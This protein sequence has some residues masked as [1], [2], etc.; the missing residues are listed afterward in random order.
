MYNLYIVHLKEQVRLKVQV[1]A[2]LKKKYLQF[3]VLVPFLKVI[4]HF[5]T[6]HILKSLQICI[7][8]SKYLFKGALQHYTLLVHLKFLQQN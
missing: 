8:A 5:W 1:P 7:R 2:H 4:V 3:E 6:L